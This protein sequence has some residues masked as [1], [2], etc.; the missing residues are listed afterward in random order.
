MTQEE[1]LIE[2]KLCKENPYYFA[3]K[4]LTVTNHKG[5]KVKFQ[6]PLDETSFNK[7]FEEYDKTI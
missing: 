7:I 6:T 5:E 3:T 4:Y 2:I 1:I